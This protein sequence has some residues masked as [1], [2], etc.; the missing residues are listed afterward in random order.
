M[1]A[2][3]TFP[4]P[5]L[6]RVE[7]ALAR[8]AKIDHAIKALE[9][10]KASE[11]RSAQAGDS[12]CL[13]EEWTAADVLQTLFE[14]DDLGIVKRNCADILRAEHSYDVVEARRIRP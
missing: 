6:R 14:E 9:A 12:W 8:G 2:P 5:R 11:I 3:A 4:D 13:V 7:S 10:L 1:N